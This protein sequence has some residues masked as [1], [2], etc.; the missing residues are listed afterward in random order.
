MG[1]TP[2]GFV[3]TGGSPVFHYPDGNASIARLLVRDLIP[4]AIPG[5][6]AK[7]IVTA[8]ADYSQLDRPGA[9]V[10]I[11]LN[12]TVVR[13]RN[14]GD[15][16]TSHGVEIAYARGD[17]VYSVRGKYCVLACW[18]MMIPYLCPE[19][20]QAQKDALHLLIKT[21]RVYTNVALRN[22]TAFKRLGIESVYAPGSYHS[23]FELNPT[24]DIGGYVSPRS[25]EQPTLIT[26]ER[27]P[28]Q[29]GL[30]ERQ[31]H[32]AGRAELLTTSFETFERNIRDQLG[33]TLGAGGF[34]PARDIEA[35]IV[36]RWPHGCAPEYNALIDGDTPPDRMPNLIGRARF[37]RIA[38]ANSDS[39]MAAYTDVAINQ[40]HRA[41]HE[42]I[43]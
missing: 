6:D 16:P 17:N 28:A 31:Q 8:R 37:G 36:N 29:P 11:R 40:A 26:M 3:S 39:G 27:T 13:A 22:W 1:Y 21:P 42:L 10:R 24:V 35:I 15:T 5:N 7:D 19:L 4:G 12:S 33:R 30:N 18:N 32:Q 9:P 20:P 14:I 25:P 41:V 38:I 23:S 43:G 2:A 34:D